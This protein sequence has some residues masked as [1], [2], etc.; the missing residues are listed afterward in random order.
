M[1]ILIGFLLLVP[2]SVS[3]PQPWRKPAHCWT[4]LGGVVT[5]PAFV[6]TPAAMYSGA[7]VVLLI[8]LSALLGTALLFDWRR[9]DVRAVDFG[10]F[11][12]FGAVIGGVALDSLSGSAT[13]ELSAL[14]A[15]L[16]AGVFVS[17]VG[18]AMQAKCNARLARDV[19][20]AAR[21]T[22]ISSAITLLV[23]LPLDVFI[24]CGLGVEPVFAWADWPLWAFCGFQSAFY[25]FSLSRLPR[26]LGYTTSYLAL[27]VGKLASSTAADELGLSGHVVHFSWRRG[28]ALALVL[29]GTWLFSAPARAPAASFHSSF[30]EP[31]SGDGGS[32]G[33]GGLRDQLDHGPARE[34]E[35]G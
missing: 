9:G 12:G 33:D 26:Y 20:S 3:A 27:L 32:G 21:S 22:A 16:L 35:E 23:G 4:L 14:A 11:V 25:I 13:S 6:T 8:Q 30:V 10:R 2:Q 1:G 28:A 19:G 17:G 15:L 5:V 24:N 7:Q 31:E 34:A 29:L 18:Y